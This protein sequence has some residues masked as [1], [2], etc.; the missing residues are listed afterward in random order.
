M[1]VC[2]ADSLGFTAGGCL[3][4]VANII[5]TPVMIPP[6]FLSLFLSHPNPHSHAFKTQKLSECKQDRSQVDPVI[7]QFFHVHPL[8][9]GADCHAAGRLCSWASLRRKFVGEFASLGIVSCG[10]QLARLL[11]LL[12]LLLLVL[13]CGRARVRSRVH[14]GPLPMHTHAHVH[15]APPTRR[16]VPSPFSPSCKRFFFSYFFRRA[17][18]FFSFIH[19]SATSD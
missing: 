11:L 12:L 14:L 8:L 9:R 16:P 2:T 1:T 6:S 17:F 13:I 7:H 3:Y 5:F 18:S 15:F 4:L 19:I 10:I